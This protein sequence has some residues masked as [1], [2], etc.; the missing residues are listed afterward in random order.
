MEI[1]EVKSLLNQVA[2]INSHYKKISTLTGENFNVFR[3]LK[4][5]SSEVR[6][7]SAFLAE[8]LNPKGSHG[9]KDKFLQLFIEQFCFKKNLINTENCK[10][11]I[12][13]HTGFIS[14]DSDE[15]GRLDIIIT[16]QK[17]GNHV[18]IENKIYAGDQKN[19]LLRY[20]HYSSQADLIYLTLNGKEPHDS[21]K[22]YLENNTH[23]KCYSYKSDI[24][25]WLETCRKE[26][27]IYPS[28][29]EAITQY[30]NLIKY[31][32]N[33]TLN[34][35]MQDEL[36]ELLKS[37]LEASFLVADNLDKAK[38]KT[39]NE[40]VQDIKQF[41]TSKDLSCSSSI[42]LKENYKGIF[43]SRKD[44]KYANIGFQF[45]SYDKA[46]IFGVVAKKNPDQVPFPIELRKSISSIIGNST[47][48][49][50]WWP[51]YK[52]FDEPYD[53]WGRYSA[54]KAMENGDLLKL[55]KDKIVFLLQAIDKDNIL[56]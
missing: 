50:S 12:E 1:K 22:G 39:I 17:S 8:L 16:D 3:I 53:N 6:M 18:I 13:K 37:N 43:I 46:L 15:G 24:L 32:T 29:R 26:V 9:Q 42:N 54:W 55:M 56:L 31:L 52:P 7:H 45:Q 10:V 20:H 41:C 14:D 38:I 5:E 25:S 2:T 28:V 23:Y 11:E 4:L 34:H 49:N 48:I 47:K 19:Q 51:W 21:S 35:T 30:I 40:F 33:Q 36:S 44:W 27:A